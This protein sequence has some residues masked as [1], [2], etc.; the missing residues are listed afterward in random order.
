MYFY[1]SHS[2]NTLYYS[3]LYSKAKHDNSI[4]LNFETIICVI[5]KDNNIEIKMKMS[6]PLNLLIH[7]HVCFRMDHITSFRLVSWKQGV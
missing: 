5:F 2:S 3:I 7:L 6:F 1:R 4:L